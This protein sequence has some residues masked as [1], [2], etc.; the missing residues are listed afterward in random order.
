[1]MKAHYAPLVEEVRDLVSDLRADDPE[2]S[3][4]RKWAKK[5]EKETAYEVTF[6]TVKRVEDENE[7]LDLGYVLACAIAADVEIVLGKNPRVVE[8]GIEGRAS[9]FVH[10]LRRAAAVER[11]LN[12]ADVEDLRG[13]IEGKLGGRLRKA[14]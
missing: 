6:R 7:Y 13:A 2:S 1:M 12:P 14:V 4:L 11:A 9:D 3:S 10:A 5:L 8:E